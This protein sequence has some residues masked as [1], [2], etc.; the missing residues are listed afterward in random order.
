MAK[1]SSDALVAEWQCHGPALLSREDIGTGIGFLG[2]NYT[3]SV[4][5]RWAPQTMLGPLKNQ[6]DCSAAGGTTLEANGACLSH[7][8]NAT[9]FLYVIRGTKWAKIKVSD[10]S[11]VSDGTESA[12]AEAA[13]SI[14][15]TKNAGG[16]EEISIGMD[17]TAYRVITAV[18]AGATDTDAAND[19]S[20]I[21]RILGVGDSGE[22]VPRVFGLGRTGGAGTAQVRVSENWLS[23]AVTM[24]SPS[25]LTAADI[26]SS[27]LT[28]TGFAL[29]L[30]YPVIGTSQGP[31]YVDSKFNNF[32]ALMPEIGQNINNCHEM[33]QI[34]WLGLVVPLALGARR[35]YGLQSEGGI[36]PER[37][38]AN[39]SPVQGRL[40]GIAG[41]QLWGYFNVY[42]PTTDDTYLCA[43]QPR[44]IDDWHTQILSYYPILTLTNTSSNFLLDIDTAS[45]ARVNPT[46]VGGEDSDVFYITRGGI[47]REPDDSNYRFNT[48]GGTWYGTEM[49]RFPWDDKEVEYVE[50]ESADCSTTE[51]LTVSL[52]VDGAAAVAL[53]PVSTD[54]YQRIKVPEGQFRGTRIAPQVAFATGAST[55]SP[56]I[57]GNLRL[58]YRRYD[59]TVDGGTRRR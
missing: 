34:S 18:G 56:K 11:L 28:F 24:K 8:M 52:S 27:E 45:G 54:G 3:D 31:Y 5:T 29:D 53:P 59:K 42:N 19:E 55:T 44:Q 15:Y 32:R 12:L 16:T 49:R 58:V 38:L 9:I 30:D 41:S 17:N 46:L 35:Q 1:A 20:A 23:S 39:T 6:I 37:Y 36:G 43:V 40:T 51:T 57:D 7:G 33:R 48:A 22:V 13:R 14:L 26:G 25:W 4:D 2:C 21:C 47:P 50:F 10:M